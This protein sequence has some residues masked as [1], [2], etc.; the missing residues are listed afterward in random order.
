MPPS[1]KTEN[2]GMETGPYFW[3]GIGSSSISFV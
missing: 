1:S 2:G 3:I